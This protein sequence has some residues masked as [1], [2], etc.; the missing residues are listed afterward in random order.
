MSSS[1]SDIKLSRFYFVDVLQTAR[2]PFVTLNDRYKR[3]LMTDICESLSF[4]S[5]Y[6]E[7]PARLFLVIH[8]PVYPWILFNTPG[9]TFHFDLD[10]GFW[11]L[12]YI[13]LHLSLLLFTIQEHSLLWGFANATFETAIELPLSVLLIYNQLHWFHVHF[14]AS[15]TFSDFSQEKDLLNCDLCVNPSYVFRWAFQRLQLSVSG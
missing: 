13:S 4:D 10:F 2:C 12:E 3:Q 5:K 8:T 6:P 15:T 1:E 14:V 11:N 7:G 9:R